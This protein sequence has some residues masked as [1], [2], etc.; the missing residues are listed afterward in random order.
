V[1]VK[2]A[3]SWV[4]AFGRRQPLV[5]GMTLTARIITERQNLFQWLFEPLFAVQRR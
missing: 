4:M 1:T 3:Q 2:L 5:P